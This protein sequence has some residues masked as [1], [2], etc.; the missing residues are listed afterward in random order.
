MI[1][2][3]ESKVQDKPSFG[4]KHVYCNDKYFSF[5]LR[6]CSPLGEFDGKTTPTY[7]G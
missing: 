7:D 2:T 1:Y 3:K 4:Y 5:F 6:Q